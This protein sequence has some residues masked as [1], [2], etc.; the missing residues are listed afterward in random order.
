MSISANSVEEFNQILKD[1]KYV[2]IGFWADWSKPSVQMN[3]IFDQL[4]KQYTQIKFLKV[5]AEKLHEVS[6]KYN[7]KSVPS[8]FFVSNGKPLHSFVGAN[9]SELNLQTI[10]FVSK[11]AQLD[12]DSQNNNNNNNGPIDEE[13]MKKLKLQEEENKKKLFQRLESLINQQKVM[14]FMKGSPD[15]PQCGFS[16]KTVEIL[17]KN[18]FV[19]GSF[20]ILSDPSVR[21]GLKE[22]SNWPTYPQLYINGKLVGGFDIIKEMDAEGELE[23]LKPTA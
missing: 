18:T 22:F 19:F 7:I 4:P 6:L 23:S 12:E 21:N 11:I 16:R 5:E 3:Q 13:T 8:Y 17:Q 20:D 2:I 10:N 14:L 1:N 15:A 9:P